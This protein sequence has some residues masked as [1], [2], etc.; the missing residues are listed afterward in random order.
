VA[1]DNVGIDQSIVVTRQAMDI[2]TNAISWK[3]PVRVATTGQTTLNGTQTIDGYALVMGERVLVRAQTNAAENGIYQVVAFG[4]WTRTADADNGS[5]LLGATVFVAAGST[6]DNT[7]W[8]MTTNAPITV[9]ATA[10]VWTQFGAGG[11]GGA[12]EVNVSTAG[13]S[14]R[15]GELLWVDT[16]EVV[17]DPPVGHRFSP[18]Y[19][20]SCA[21]LNPQAQSPSLQMTHG[22]GV[23]PLIM[24]HLEDGSWASFINWRCDEANTNTTTVGIYMLNT[25]T[26][27]TAWAVLRFRLLY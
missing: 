9:G 25:S 20:L 11:G 14:P 8:Q 17:V 2:A 24:G 27:T 13:P 26:S 5:K 16:D 1:A 18:E 6:L 3:Q 15:V 21:A 22:L 12:A 23:R 10:Q 4:A 7:T 19:V